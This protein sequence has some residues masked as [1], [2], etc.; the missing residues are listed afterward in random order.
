MKWHI[1]ISKNIGIIDNKIPINTGGRII[2]KKD[3]NLKVGL[4]FILLSR[5]WMKKKIN[6]IIVDTNPSNKYKTI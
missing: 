1:I 6:T 3:L 4:G 2:G 5:L